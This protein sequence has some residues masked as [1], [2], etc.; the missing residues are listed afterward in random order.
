MISCDD[1]EN[2][3]VS[4]SSSPRVIGG[5]LDRCEQPA[6]LQI[7]R[8]DLCDRIG[9]LAV[10]LT[11]GEKFRNRDRQRLEISLGNVEADDRLGG[12]RQHGQAAGQRAERKRAAAR[13]QKTGSIVTRN[14]LNPL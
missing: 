12:A 2:R 6:A 10:V 5:R 9:G 4:T 8:D 3:G 7:C 14:H 11:G 1:G 13:Q